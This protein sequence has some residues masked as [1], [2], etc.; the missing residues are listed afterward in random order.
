[1]KRKVVATSH[2][3]ILGLDFLRDVES[4]WFQSPKKGKE[5]TSRL[6]EGKK[7]RIS[8]DGGLSGRGG[9][10]L[11]KLPHNLGSKEGWGGGMEK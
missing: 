2:D 7:V 1:M 6:L 4:S 9:D 8:K 3:G 10:Y 11:E 5:S